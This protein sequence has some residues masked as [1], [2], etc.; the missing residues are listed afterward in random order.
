MV[1]QNGTEQLAVE[2]PHVLA[3]REQFKQITALDV[4]TDLVRA[5]ELGDASFR[6][7][8]PLFRS[9]IA[10]V[11]GLETLP[12]G[13]LS[14]NSVDQVGRHVN[15]LAQVL[16][17][18]KS[19]ALAGDPIPARDSMASQVS[20][21]FDTF[22]D[23]TLNYVGYLSWKAVDLASIR[24][25]VDLVM[26]EATRKIDDTLRDI[27]EKN[28]Q[29]DEALVAIRAASATAGVAH[30]AETFAATATRHEGSAGAWLKA[31][32]AA[33]LATVIAGLAVVLAWEVEGNLSDASTFQLVAGKAIILAVGLIATFTCLRLYR[34]HAHL[35]IVAKHREDALRTFR[36]FA[37]GAA[38][39]ETKDKVLLEATHAVFAPAATG[40]VDGRDGSESIEILDGVTGLLRRRG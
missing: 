32:I 6:D 29:A 2:S 22:R 40:L 28:R 15:G 10:H 17:N 38:D 21:Q 18:V 4:E 5:A 14:E 19:F 27:A 33:G 12:W 9:I 25:R 36:A 3:L 11:R 7:S 1:S 16:G 31:S 20:T 23:A 13:E 24:D 35:A 30:H 8:A 39:P 37:D 34:S 26:T